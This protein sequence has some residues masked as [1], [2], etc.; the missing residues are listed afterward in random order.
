M[1]A[2]ISTTGSRSDPAAETH[3]WISVYVFYAS[4]ADPLLVECVAPLVRRLRADGLVSGYFFI[5]YW[6]E[7]RHVRLR[8]LPA[9]GVPAAVVTAE[10]EADLAGF[11][12]RRP[13]PPA[14]AATPEHYRRLFLAEYDQRRWDA[15][16]G[17]DGT[18][19]LRDNNSFHLEAYE[20]E[21]A[22]Y[23][24]LAGVEL[25][26]WHFETS[27]DVALRLLATGGRRSIRLGQSAQLGMIL[28][29]V[30]LDDDA[31]VAEFL[32]GYRDFWKNTY[33]YGGVATQAG[34]ELANQRGT[35]RLRHVIDQIRR[36]VR[37]GVDVVAPDWTAHCRQL[38][39]RLIELTTSGG[40]ELPRADAT[41]P[42][43]VLPAMLRSYLHMTNNRLGVTIREEAYLAHVLR[44][45][46]LDDPDQRRPK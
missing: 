46:L 16:Y 14:E 22:R 43:V 26:E 23:G 7:G 45:A 24:G 27:S 35:D 38:R 8:L 20:R 12:S 19:P 9:P 13:A 21:L 6:Q 17:P 18:M 3:R 40:I 11:L 32:A 1:A 33:R 28:C 34:Y 30:F 25:A 37:H 44:A 29:L 10:T 15:R 41:D 42:A 39:A 5:R 4:D 31:R 36:S 2:P